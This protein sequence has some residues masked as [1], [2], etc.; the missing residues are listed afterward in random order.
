[1]LEDQDLEKFKRIVAKRL[2]VTLR[3]IEKLI[4]DKKRELGNLV[5]DTA[6]LILIGKEHGIEL[7]EKLPEIRKIFELHEVP[8]GLKAARIRALVIKVK[9]ERKYARENGMLRLWKALLK[10]V[11]KPFTAWLIAWNEAIENVKGLEPGDIVILSNVKT[12]KGKYGLEICVRD[13]SKVEHVQKLT[14]FIHRICDLKRNDERVKLIGVVKQA[15]VKNE[16]TFIVLSD[17]SGD[18][19]VVTD[20][21]IECNH[22]DVLKVTNG[23][24]IAAR[25]RKVIFTNE[26][27]LILGKIANVEKLFMRDITRERNFF[28]V[29]FDGLVLFKDIQ[30][31][32]TP[33]T[34][35]YKGNLMVALNG[36][37]YTF[38]IIDFHGKVANNLLREGNIFRF[39]KILAY[40]LG[41][42]KVL[43]TSNETDIELL[44]SLSTIKRDEFK[45]VR[46]TV[47]RVYIEERVR[48]NLCGAVVGYKGICRR[49][50]KKPTNP[51]KEV[52]FKIIVERDGEECS[53]KATKRLTEKMIRVYG[54]LDKFISSVQGKSALFICRK[55]K[56]GLYALYSLSLTT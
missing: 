16:C 37:V 41:K 10:S 21:L 31:I 19:L 46:A 5:S 53:L 7:K 22:G 52:I 36:K 50:G 44:G 26:K 56:D 47:K 4:Q 32:K 9:G 33:R 11:G 15:T 2:G 54:D 3:E 20:M 28:L 1:V 39:K 55:I 17:D 27:P 8:T 40:H 23:K 34:A 35:F 49:C 45:S 13:D 18:A 43:V 30:L 38:E 29:T 24:V 51:V 42:R 12:R 6:A 48:C 14:E 25:P